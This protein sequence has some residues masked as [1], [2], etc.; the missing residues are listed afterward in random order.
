MEVI[1]NFFWFKNVKVFLLGRNFLLVG[2][3]HIHRLLSF[4]VIIL[5]L[6]RCWQ[7]LRSL[8]LVWLIRPS[9]L[10]EGATTYPLVT[11]GISGA[12]IAGAILILRI[13]GSMRLIGRVALPLTAL[14]VFYHL[15]QVLLHWLR[16][17]P[18]RVQRCVVSTLHLC[19]LVVNVHAPTA[20]KV[21]ITYDKSLYTTTMKVRN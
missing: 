17:L 21:T 12:P 8:N 11:I 14:L 15:S 5:H 1:L 7:L 20:W 19:V 10:S 18:V 16:Q 9:R 6:L 3:H 2:I 4:H 13:G